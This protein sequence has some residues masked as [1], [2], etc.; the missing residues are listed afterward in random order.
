MVFSV[1]QE[2]P[3]EIQ[4][5]GCTTIDI[6]IHIYIKYSEKPKKIKLRHTLCLENYS[7]NTETHCL[8]YDFENPSEELKQGLMKG[9]GE[10]I[11]GTRQVNGRDNKYYVVLSDDNNKILHKEKHIK[12]NTY[13]FIEP[14][15]WKNKRKKSDRITST[16]TDELPPSLNVLDVDFKKLLSRVSMTD[17]EIEMVS[18]VYCSYSCYEKSGDDA[19]LLPPISDPIYRMPEL[20]SSLK[21][22]L[23]SIEA[24]YGMH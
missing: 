10:I 14:I 16:R 24:D 17:K 18:Q 19:L 3:Y 6:P 12:E 7:K 22:S 2:P 15:K 4:E 5:S 13:K 9:G 1:I 23:C 21:R 20:P 8:Y 11:A